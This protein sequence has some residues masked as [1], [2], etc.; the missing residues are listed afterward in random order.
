M[1]NAPK[2]PADKGTPTDNVP[3]GP[4]ESRLPTADMPKAPDPSPFKVGAVSPGSAK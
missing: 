2:H 3:A 4:I 1:E